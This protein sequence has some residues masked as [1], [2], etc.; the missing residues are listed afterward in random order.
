[1][2]ALQGRRILVT[3][4]A[5]G[6]GRAFAEALL[7]AGAQVAVADILRERGAACAAELGRHPLHGFAGAEEC[8]G[9]VDG[10]DALEPCGAIGGKGGDRLDNAGV[11]DQGR[12]RSVFIGSGEEVEHVCLAGDVGLNR[13]GRNA[14]GLHFV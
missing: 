10:H 13:Y 11:I 3:G 1:M 5:R 9:D 4:A 14:E 12:E 6:L 2:T 7:G 8:S